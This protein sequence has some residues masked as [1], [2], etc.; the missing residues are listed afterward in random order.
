MIPLGNELILCTQTYNDTNDFRKFGNT[1]INSCSVDLRLYMKENYETKF[2]QMYLKINDN[3]FQIIPVRINNNNKLVKRFFLVYNY[4]EN[5]NTN[6]GFL[7]AND[8]KFEVQLERENPESLS[9]MK[10]PLLTINYDQFEYPRENNDEILKDFSFTSNYYMDLSKIMKVTIVFFSI[11]FVLVFIIVAARMYVWCILNPA[12]LTLGTYPCYF[13]IH[14]IFKIFKY[15][16]IIMF[17][18]TWAL[19]GFWY[20]FYKCQYRPFVF[21]PNLFES[22]WNHY[23]K[24]D[25]LWGLACGSYGLYMCFRI[26]QQINCDIFFIDWEHDKDILETVM[27]KTTNK[28]YKSPW[29]SIHIV[30]QFNLLQKTRTISIPFCFL[31]FI[32]LYYSKYLLWKHYTQLTPNVSWAEHSPENYLLRH[33]LGTFILFMTGITQYVLRRIIQPWVPTPTTEFLD[34]CSVANVSVLILQDS[35]RGYYVHG[36]SPL[37]KADVTLQELI[38]FLEEEGKGKIKG[39]GITD[40]KND[41][42]QTYEIYLSYTMRQIYDGLYFFPTIQEIDKG[43]QYDRI[44]N[45]AKFMNI[46]KYIPDSLHTGNI[47]EINKFMNNHLKEKIE[48]VTMQ[49][50]LLVKNKSLCERFF[51]FPPSIDLTSRTVK[52]LVFYK[53]PGQN[54]EDV[55]FLGM[56]LEWLIFVIYIWEM[57]CLSLEKYGQSLPISIF[58][59]YVMERMFYKIRV[60]FGEKNVAKKAVVDNRFL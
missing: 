7:Y 54:F 38:R 55:L 18:Y 60:F 3:N 43:N 53:D 49:S 56:E 30:N 14:L 12:K 52:E 25:I 26:Y 1:I 2:Y 6:D 47:Y 16:G 57:W 4:E 41:N 50:K 48:Q 42:L 46:F 19:T 58:M 44:Q 35:L 24:F 10:M 29:R 5:G 37:G 45:Q 39:R 23:R 17:F 59:T 31:M 34:L 8:I 22:Y 20:I 36:Q 33:F 32:M 27:G 11:C 21:F 15:F 40:D 13:L 9:H 28:P 51:E